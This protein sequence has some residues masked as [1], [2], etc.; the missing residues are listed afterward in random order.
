M[1]ER[2]ILM[3]APMVQALLAGSKTQTRRVVKPQPRYDADWD[4]GS[5]YITLHKDRRAL[6]LI[7]SCKDPRNASLLLE[8]CPYGQPG[9]VLYVREA[10][11]KLPDGST[12]YR[13]SYTDQEA[14]AAKWKP[15][16][17]LPKS[18]SRLWLKIVSVRVERL[19]DISEA[20]AVAEG[21]EHVCDWPTGEHDGT[22]AVTRALYR[23]YLS[24]E[25]ST[26]ADP[27]DIV[28]TLAGVAEIAAQAWARASYRSLWESING[29]GSW[30]ENPWVWRVE[31]RLAEMPF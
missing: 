25:K 27:Y 6:G 29:P 26:A 2:P 24:T 9:D 11:R 22:S 15:G 30:D 23:N 3:S 16:I 12:T 10:W 14:A 5:Y 1:K 4:G 13:A 8:T 17:H 19:Q 7:A 28:A 20:D 31:F 21:I 18:E